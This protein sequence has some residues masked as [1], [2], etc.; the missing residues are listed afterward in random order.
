MR[1]LPT[2]MSERKV[3]EIIESHLVQQNGY[4]PRLHLNYD[5]TY[6]VDKELLLQFLSSTQSEVVDTL[7]RRYGDMFETRLFKR[8]FDQIKKK[9]IVHVL[10]NGVKEGEF[11]LTLYYKKPASSKLNMTAVKNYQSNIFSVMRQVHYSKKTPNKSLDMVLFIN[12]LPIVTM[13]LKNTLTKQSVHDAIRQYQKD[14][15]PKEPLFELGRCLVHFAVDDQEVYM[16]TMLNGENTVFLPFNKG[17]NYGK[18]NPPNPF[19]LKTDYLWR[20]ILT[21]ESLSLIIEKYAQ[22]IEEKDEET[23]KVKRKL[24]FP[25]YHQFEV[26]RLLLKRARHDGAGHRYLIQHSAG[27]GKSNSITWLAHQLV[28]L[29]DMTDEHPVFDSVIVVTDRKVLDKQLRN[30]IKQFAQVDGVIGAA[31]NSAELRAYLEVGKKIIVTTIQKFPYVVDGID[32]L[33]QYKFAI[34]IDEAH[35]SQG[36]NTAAKMNAIL[37]KDETDE[38]ELTAEDKINQFIESRKMPPNVSYFAFTATPKNKTLELFGEKQSDGTFKPFHV[39][40]MRQ[41]IEEGFILDV[42]QNYTTYNSY[43]KLY[44][45]IEDDPQFDSRRAKSKMRQFVETHE[46]AIEKKAEIMIDHFLEY[47]YRKRKINGKAKAMVVTRS[48]LSAIRYKEAFDRILK[49]RN[50]GIEAIVAFEG[51]REIDGKQY[52][53]EIMNGF[54]SEDIPKMFKLDKYR[55]LIVAEKFQTGFDEPLLHTMY[56]DKV[57]S[58]V[59]AVQTLSRLNRAYKPYKKDTF[60]LD[61]V[62]TAEDIKEAFEPYYKTTILS[63]ETDPNRLNDL[64]DELDHYQVYTE[65]E[66][67]EFLHLYVDGA[68][69]EVLDPKLEAMVERFKQLPIDDQVKF[70]KQARAFVRTYNFLSQLLPFNNK[71]WTSRAVTLQF[72]VAKLPKLTQDDLGEGVLNAV[73]LDSYRLEQNEK[74]HIQLEGDVVLDPSSANVGGAITDPKMEYLSEIV[75]DFN[76]KFGKNITENDSVRKFMLEEL[77]RQVVAHEEYQNTKKYSDRQNAKI[78]FR[79][80]L[81]KVFQDYMFDQFEMYQ[82]FM[83]DEEFAEWYTNKMFEADYRFDDNIHN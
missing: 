80:I 4:V 8:I 5:A 41:A 22:L 12:G 3:E 23:N 74:K 11:K 34:I 75:R 31:T 68:E 60:V 66:V 83:E 57:L 15:D 76:E 56:V 7:K 51:S 64:Q 82:K 48:V 27:S 29:K 78:T 54:P 81:E 61:F 55:F 20:D 46:L 44:K 35:S 70:K 73:D 39:Y 58:D 28:E 9:G 59:K 25:R 21:K 38:E 45:K 32:G 24:I 52:S 13:E 69:R 36:G 26:V 17:Y 37:S 42:L 10:R 18:G 6:C 71:E 50:A 33:S 40:S 19:G 63:E 62:N 16:T 30:N 67:T 72:L 49:E 47:V 65:E 53:E 43:Y 79:R 2:D 14:R 77:P 1:N